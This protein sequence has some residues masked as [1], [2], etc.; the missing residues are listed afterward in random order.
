LK[1]RK[2]AQRNL[3]GAQSISLIAPANPKYSEELLAAMNQKLNALID[4]EFGEDKALF[5][6][7]KK[8]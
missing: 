5:T 2:L 6:P 3:G 8:D 4:E 7:P 1:W